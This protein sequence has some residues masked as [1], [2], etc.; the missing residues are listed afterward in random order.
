MIDQNNFTEVLREVKEIFRTSPEMSQDEIL[1]YFKDMEL[2]DEQKGLITEYLKT[3]TEEEEEVQ[4]DGEIIDFDEQ[5][6][7]FSLYLEDIRKIKEF[8]EE[9]MNTMYCALLQGDDTQISKIC[10]ANL[11]RVAVLADEYADETIGV[12]DIIQEG[13]MAMFIRLTELC[14]MGEECGYEVEEELADAVNEAMKKYV[15]KMT[16]GR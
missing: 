4:Q 13:N 3:P 8:T 6:K 16:E 7:A 14:G 11:A 12:E 2:T 15:E 5:S 9:E 10:D 1:S